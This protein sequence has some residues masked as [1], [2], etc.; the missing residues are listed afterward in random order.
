VQRIIERAARPG[1]AC[2]PKMG[3]VVG[4]VGEGKPKDALWRGKIE[5]LQVGAAAA[6]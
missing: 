6:R 4:G 3:F 2:Q 5:T 1:R